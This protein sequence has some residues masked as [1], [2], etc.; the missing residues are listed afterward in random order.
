MIITQHISY[1]SEC[2]KEVYHHSNCDSLKVITPIDYC[3]TCCKFFKGIDDNYTITCSYDETLT[4]HENLK[5]LEH[6]DL[7]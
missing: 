7:K 3:I 5:L 1:V 6:G 4:Y 2:P